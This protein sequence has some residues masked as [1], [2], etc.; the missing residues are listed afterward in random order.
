MLVAESRAISFYVAERYRNQAIID[1]NVDK[2]GKL[3][4][5]YECRLSTAKPQRSEG[6]FF[7]SGIS[8]AEVVK[9][10]DARAKASVSQSK[11]TNDKYV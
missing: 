6:H 7:S 2:L 5:A 8:F 4:D 1:A 10:G 9:R 3:L 11:D